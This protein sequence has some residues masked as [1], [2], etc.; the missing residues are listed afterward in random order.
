VFERCDLCDADFSGRDLDGATFIG[1]RFRGAA[2]RP[3]GTGGWQVIDADFSAASDGSDLGGAGDLLEQLGRD[4]DPRMAD[5]TIRYSTGNEHNPADPWGR[6]ELVVHADGRA[7]LDHH[8]SRGGSAR[9]WTGQV[10]AAPL[11]ALGAALE[12]SGFPAVPGPGFLPPDAT[13]RCLVVEADGSAQQ[14]SL[15]W[16]QTPSL[17][18]YATVFD[19]LDGVIRQLSSE[20]VP[21]QSTQP[22]IVRDI[23]PQ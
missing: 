10:D 2:G 17:P 4:Y 9:A 3:S 18:G 23:A 5:R 13:V 12:E 21:Y 19:I 11:G 14:A 1:G 20:A 22:P 8:F 6:S 16:H 7:R 15:G